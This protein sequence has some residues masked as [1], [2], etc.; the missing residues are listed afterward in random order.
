MHSAVQRGLPS[1]IQSPTITS[2]GSVSQ[3]AARESIACLQS[4]ALPNAP[5]MRTNLALGDDICQGTFFSLDCNSE[6]KNVVT[7][8]WEA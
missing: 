8:A 7:R 3:F 4:L 1:D 5:A 2:I 6:A